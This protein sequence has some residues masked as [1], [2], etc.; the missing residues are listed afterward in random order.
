MISC[1]YNEGTER[2]VIRS[3]STTTLWTSIS[4]ISICVFLKLAHMY[5]NTISETFCKYF[6][7]Q[8]MR[9]LEKMSESISRKTS[10][11]QMELLRAL[12]VQTVSAI[13]VSFF[14]CVISF[15][16]PIFNMDLGRLVSS[17]VTAPGRF[18]WKLS[19]HT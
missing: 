18:Q 14:S 10:K 19:N 13:F 11:L 8:I 15:I 12:I 17:T 6:E 4:A 16:I 3:W 1:L 7:F 2:T 9:K 5:G